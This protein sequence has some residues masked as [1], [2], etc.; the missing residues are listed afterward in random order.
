MPD[1]APFLGSWVKMNNSASKSLIYKYCIPTTGGQWG[2]IA[3]EDLERPIPEW[4]FR[5]EYCPD[6]KLSEIEEVVDT[7][8]SIY[9]LLDVKGNEYTGFPKSYSAEG[10]PGTELQH[11]TLVMDKLLES[12][13][14]LVGE[15]G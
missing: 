6:W 7:P 12:T 3:K 14:Y 5:L 2:K 13:A 11:L 15:T 10:I 1:Q 4:T 9:S 8:N